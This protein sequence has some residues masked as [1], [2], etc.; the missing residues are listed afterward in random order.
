M[1]L[2]HTQSSVN[3]HDD[4]HSTS[5]TSPPLNNYNSKP[6][7]K[8]PSFLSSTNQY[9]NGPLFRLHMWRLLLLVL[10]IAAVLT[11][12]ALTL[13]P[14][15]LPAAIATIVAG[16]SIAAFNGIFATAVSVATAST[17]LFA[18][19]FFNKSKPVEQIKP[20][21]TNQVGKTDSEEYLDNGFHNVNSVEHKDNAI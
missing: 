5:F 16:L 4:L 6:V 7:T 14:V 10:A 17:I 2:F 11:I 21:N 15:V 13:N 1:P 19:S 12:V 20:V 8:E 3:Q 9:L 18:Q